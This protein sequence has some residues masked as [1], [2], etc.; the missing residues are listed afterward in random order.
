VER[1]LHSAR[2]QADGPIGV[3]FLVPFL[4][5]AAV[6]AAARNA[7][8]VEFFW[9]EPE[10]DLVAL[11]KREGA[12]AAWQTG[13]AAEAR[14]A[15]RAGC[16]FVVVQGVEA[17]GHVRG[18]QPL[19]EVLAE[20]LDV[21]DIPAVAA[22]GIGTAEQAAWALRSGAA[23]VRAG[24]RF[25]AAAESAAHP[26]Y[27]AALIAATREETV[28][29]E[30]FGADWPD[31][32]HRVLRVALEA[33]ERLRSEVVARLGE[34]EIPRFSSMPQPGGP[35]GGHGDGAVCGGIGR[36]GNGSQARCRDRRRADAPG[37]LTA[38]WLPAGAGVSARSAP[39]SCRDG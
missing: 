26:A 24:T 11:A 21:L 33:A 22:G 36:C 15:E 30:A 25:V 8:V 19:G 17:G 37:H 29:T 4:D 14:A 9:A 2:R 28:L 6:A 23:A 12:L 32:P 7:D 3:S 39:G 27:V 5:R 1:S 34:E 35:G 10:P 31:A 20:A 18:S 38:A 16:D 13:S